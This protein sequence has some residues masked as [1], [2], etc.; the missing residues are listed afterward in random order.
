MAPAAAR[1][2]GKNSFPSARVALT[3]EAAGRPSFIGCPLIVTLVPGAKSL[4]R[5]CI[6]ISVVG[7]SASKPHVTTLP[8]APVTSTSSQECGFVYLEFLDDALEGDVLGL[9]EHRAGMVRQ[10]RRGEE[11]RQADAQEDPCRHLLCSLESSLGVKVKSVYWVPPSGVLC[12]SLLGFSP[13][14]Q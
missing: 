10:H 11:S 8:S 2:R 5:T 14:C 12:T 4:R 13:Q 9:V 3:H 1:P 7:P 6:I